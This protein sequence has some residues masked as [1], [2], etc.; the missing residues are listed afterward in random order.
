MLL[1][2]WMPVLAPSA[3]LAAAPAC[4]EPQAVTTPCS[5]V[6]LPHDLAGDGLLCLRTSLPKLKNEMEKDKK[7]Y[8]TKLEAKNNVISIM[9]KSSEKQDKLLETALDLRLDPPEFY[10][11]PG[12]WFGVGV[13]VGGAV[14]IGIAYAFPSK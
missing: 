14:A 9:R 5:G 4:E 13:L 12:F 11:K 8:E 1:A 3:A 6:L 2:L 7:I 10:E